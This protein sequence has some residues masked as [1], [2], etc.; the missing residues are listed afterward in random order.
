MANEK[1]GGTPKGPILLT[2]PVARRKAPARPAQ[3]PAAA[4]PVSATPAGKVLED[5]E[6]TRPSVRPQEG[7]PLSTHSGVFRTFTGQEKKG[8]QADSG[9]T[10]PQA[11]Q[12]PADREAEIE[13]LRAGLAEANGKYEKLLELTKGLAGHVK[14]LED[15][16]NAL[17][18]NV[19]KL[20]DRKTAPVSDDGATSV[21]SENL[22]DI[23]GS[24]LVHVE[25]SKE[26]SEGGI[27]DLK[28]LKKSQKVAATVRTVAPDVMEAIFSVTDAA[29]AQAST[30]F[31]TH[32]QLNAVIDGIN[33]RFE[34]MAQTV[35]KFISTKTEKLAAALEGVLKGKKEG[36]GG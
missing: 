24:R 30:R 15:T 25:A 22:L 29:L 31:V 9:R 1:D 5:G 28:R 34:V 12:Q 11:P 6:P 26:R 20:L 4:R 36:N 32:D 19:A 33:A 3:A 2:E 27:I 7:D 13:S 23:E 16:A 8:G 17:G 21:F 14:E 18:K 35:L 10:G